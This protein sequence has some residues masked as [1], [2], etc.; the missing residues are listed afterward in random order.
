MGPIHQLGAAIV[1]R[2]HVAA[3]ARIV[4]HSAY[5]CGEAWVEAGLVRVCAIGVAKL[6]DN[7]QYGCTQNGAQRVAPQTQFWPLNDFG[8]ERRQYI[9]GDDVPVHREARSHW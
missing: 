2:H 7:A 8:D 6:D 1:G 9:G 5:G 3:H 4:Q